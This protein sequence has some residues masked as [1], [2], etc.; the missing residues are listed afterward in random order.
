MKAI[1]TALFGIGTLAA[2]AIVPTAANADGARS[3]IKDGPYE[4]PF[5]WTGFYVGG[6]IGGGWTSGSNIIGD[7]LPSPVAYGFVQKSID[8]DGRGAVGGGQIGYNWQ[9]A[10]TVVLGLEADFSWSGVRGS[11]RVG[12]IES[13][14]PGAS[15]VPG[16]FATASQDVDWLGSIRGRLGYASGRS[17]VYATGGVAWAHVKYAADEVFLTGVSNPGS[18]STTKTGWVIAGQFNS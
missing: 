3:S 10:P 15:Y 2:L 7:P 4:R 14:P 1:C 6:H 8:T 11:G 9:V 16:S 12:P 17:L 13:I 18:L 5:S